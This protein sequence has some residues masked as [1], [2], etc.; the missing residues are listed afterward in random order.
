[1]YK[2]AQLFRPI[3]EA[4][5]RGE[6]P[7]EG[8]RNLIVEPQVPMDRRR[9]LQRGG[10]LLGGAGM[11]AAMASPAAAEQDDAPSIEGLWQGVVSGPGFPPFE[12]FELY[13]GTIWISSG[14]TDLTP[15][16]M[17]SSLWSTFKQIGPRAYRGIG[18]FWTYNWNGSAGASPNGYGA[19]VQTT[20]LSQDGNAYS[21][22]GPLQFYDNNGRP[23]GAPVVITDQGV[24]IA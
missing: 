24:R 22:Q 1:M 16:A 5:A 19:Y 6:G 10:A 23:V 20:I 14:Q 2:L 17:D 13:G 18:R 15:A 21:G 4:A 9:I 7:A 12:T 11:L 3:A 8:D